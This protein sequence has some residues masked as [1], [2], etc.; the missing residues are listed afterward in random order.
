L[1]R[2]ARSCDA[3]A[4]ARLW[5]EA[6]VTSRP[7]GRADPYSR[8]DYSASAARGPV[9]V[10]EEE[11]EVVGVVA[12]YEPAAEGRVAARDG[13]AELS[14]LAVSAGSRRRGIGARLVERCEELARAEGW[15]AIA[16]WSRPWQTAAH[17]LYE[18]RGYIRAPERDDIDAGGGWQLVYLR[19]LG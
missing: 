2:P 6:Y 12:L 15:Q 14:R 3:E 9:L 16:L 10:A 19:R 5:T 1:I 7:G 17:S 18:A 13:E 4:V 11:G 8:A